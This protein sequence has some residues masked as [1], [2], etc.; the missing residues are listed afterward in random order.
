[1]DAEADG[2]EIPPARKVK[3]GGTSPRARQNRAGVEPQEMA[4]IRMRFEGRTREEIAAHFGVHVR[5]VTRWFSS[6]AVRREIDRQRA[7]A[8]AEISA[9]F[10]SITPEVVATFRELLHSPDERVRARVVL[11][12]LD[13]FLTP[14]GDLD[15]DPGAIPPIPRGLSQVLEL[16]PD[17]R[18]EDVT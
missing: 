3:T 4:A 18:G 12:F 1:M 13:R 7:T 2:R 15:D 16:P 11:W 17:R 6:L 5:T 9:E 8:S 10:T 14:A